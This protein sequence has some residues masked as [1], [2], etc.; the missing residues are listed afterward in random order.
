MGQIRAF[1]R[2]DFSAF[3]APA[4]A[5][6]A[7]KSELK[8][9]RI[10]PICDQSDPLWS[11]TYHPCLWFQR[12]QSDTGTPDTPGKATPKS[13]K[14]VKSKTSGMTVSP[15]KTQSAITS[16]KGSAT[17]TVKDSKGTAVSQSMLR[18]TWLT[19]QPWQLGLSDL[20]QK[21]VRLAQNGTNLELLK[22]SF[23]IFWLR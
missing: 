20:G 1:V 3:G 11:Q 15:K 21:L 9:P 14:D 5:P 22:I 7:L 2:S 12:H 18:L 13:P 17:F 6:N 4:P 8:K 19:K 23:S 10:C 16:R